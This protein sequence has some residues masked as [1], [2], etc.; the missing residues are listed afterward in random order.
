M[1]Q[2]LI[3]NLTLKCLSRFVASQIPG[4]PF[5]PGFFFDVPKGFGLDSAS[6][7]PARYDLAT[8]DPASYDLAC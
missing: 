4:E 7:G 8:Y 5:E 3:P 6:Y 2:L 1:I